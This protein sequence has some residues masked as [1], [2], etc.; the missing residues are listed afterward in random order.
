MGHSLLNTENDAQAFIRID[1]RA[2]EDIK[3]AYIF[4]RKLMKCG[5][6]EG[7]VIFRAMKAIYETEE[8]LQAFRGVFGFVE[9]PRDTPEEEEEKAL[10]AFRESIMPKGIRRKLKWILSDRRAARS[11]ALPLQY[12]QLNLSRRV[13]HVRSALE[14]LA[15]SGYDEEGWNLPSSMPPKP[16]STKPA[17]SVP[18]AERD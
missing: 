7:E 5:E 15:N 2:T 6:R 16:A 11:L 3:E 13:D 1:K 14:K 4:H 8:A 9:P 18:P 10:K 17:S 12:A